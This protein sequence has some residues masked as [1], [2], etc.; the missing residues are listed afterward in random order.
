LAEKSSKFQSEEQ[1]V[2]LLILAAI[3][4]AVTSLLTVLYLTLAGW[5]ETFFQN[6]IGGLQIGMFWPLI[7]LIIGGI[8]VGIA[9]RLT[10]EHSYM[11]STQKEYAENKGRLNYRYLPSIILQCIIS[12]WSGAS[13]GPEGGLADLGGG[14][15]TLIVERLKVQKEAVLFLTC[16]GVSGS[17]SAFF[18]NPVIGAVVAMEYL[19]IQ[20]IPYV[21]LLIPGLVAGAIGYLVYFEIL[22]TS[23][24]GIVAFPAF[25]AP[26]LIDLVWALLIGMIGGLLAVYHKW[27]FA[28]LQK[29]LFFRLKSSPIKR[30][31]IGGVIVGLIG[32]FVPLVLYSGQKEIVTILFQGSVYSIGFLILL[33]FGKS[34]VM[35]ISFNTAFKGGPVFPY[36]FMGGILGLVMSQSLPFIPEG[37]AVTGGM[38][39]VSAGLFPIPISV[40]LL[41]GLMS[42]LNLLPTIAIASITGFVISRFLAPP[43]LPPSPQQV[44]EQD[45]TKTTIKQPLAPSAKVNQHNRLENQKIPVKPQLI[46]KI[47]FIFEEGKKYRKKYLEY[48]QVH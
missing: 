25:T 40:I 46:K 34:F 17:F 1:L 44:Q 33:L 13:V 37:V 5:G 32:S 30:G 42:Q 26:S 3:I 4:G 21:K 28:Q 23:L 38:A 11:G 29:R 27:L 2:K 9:I 39:A 47:N 48:L 15:A 12:L 18:G 43:K 45:E 7:L 41:I 36:L 20:G 31:L 22:G 19:F 14:T 16:C 8:V 6:P 24:S 35:A 10:G